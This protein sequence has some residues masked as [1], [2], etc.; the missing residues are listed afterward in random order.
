MERVLEDFWDVPGDYLNLEDPYDIESY[1][2]IKN[3]MWTGVVEFR[4]TNPESKASAPPDV[5]VASSD[6]TPVH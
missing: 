2:M 6:A 3:Q 1:D 5:T 4:K